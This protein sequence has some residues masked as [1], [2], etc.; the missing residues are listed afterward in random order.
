MPGCGVIR[1]KGGR[2]YNSFV[3]TAAVGAATVTAAADAWACGAAES[4]LHASEA[5]AGRSK[6]L[7]GFDSM[8]G[9][10]WIAF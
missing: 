5:A 3:L 2:S 10:H 1:G 4:L 8:H 6:G 9:R 7:C